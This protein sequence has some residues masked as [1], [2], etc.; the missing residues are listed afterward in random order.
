M[1][2]E[3]LYFFDS[4]SSDTSSTNSNSVSMQLIAICVCMR[5]CDHLRKQVL[6]TCKI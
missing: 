5:V 2:T 3:D 6:S 4:D 1:D